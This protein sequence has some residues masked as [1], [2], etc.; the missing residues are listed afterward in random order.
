MNTR[1]LAL[2]VCGLGFT[3]ALPI[4]AANFDWHRWRGPDLNG[5][6]KETGWS[7]TW[8]ASGPKQLWK[9]SVGTGFSSVCVAEG[10]AYTMGN[11]K[12]KESVYCFDAAT[13]AEVWQHTYDCDL[14]PRYYD[15]GPSAT[16]TVDG[17]KVYALSR[18]GHLFCFDA[19]SGKIDWQKNVNDELGLKVFKENTPEWGYSGSPLVQGGKLILNVG[20]AGAAF[21]KSSGK[22]IWTTGKAL[23]G[24]STHVPFNVGAEAY[25]A[26]FGAKGAYAVALKDGK[27]L[28][29]FPFETSYDVNAADPIISGNKVFV[30]AGYG[31]GAA[32]FQFD[33]GQAAKIWENKNMRNQ[34]NSCV[35]IDGHLYGMDG[36][37]GSRGS[38]LRCIEFATGKVKWTEPSVK[39]GALMA[40]DGKL[41]I[42]SEP[43]ELVVAQAS[44]ESFKALARAQVMGGKCWT[45]PVLS[46]R[47]IYC[48]N[49]KGDVVCVDVSAKST[50][51]AG[52][53]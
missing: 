46:N 7:A 11:R 49:S 13:G 8:P 43:G 47:R 52:R 53:N 33:G 6:S 27:Q 32:L 26:V 23:S 5:I 25:L 15:G 10:R 4:G 17:D 14:D 38:A 41:I 50:A 22:V 28:W 36:D 9:T 31:H 51:A 19:A 37:H 40:A 29:E 24:Y 20:T 48:R 34:F 44:P 3:A 42:M 16:P 18:K 12:D 35:L 30:S 1:R 2:F 39:P 45:T 21:D